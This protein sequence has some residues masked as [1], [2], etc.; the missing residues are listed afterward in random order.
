VSAAS[1]P[2]KI[3]LA[4]LAVEL[5][6]ADA[7]RII[8]WAAETFG[9]GLVLTSSFGAQS[10]VM[11]H[12]VTQVVPEIPVIL[13]DTGYLFPETYQFAHELTERLGLNLKIYTPR[14]TTGYL[15]AVHGRL[16]EQGVEGLTRYHEIVKIEPMQRALKELKVTAWIAGLRRQQ[17]DH[18]ASLRAVEA[19]DGQYKIHPILDWTT[20]DVHEYLKKHDL[21]YHPLY[22]KGYKSIG[23]VHS[24]APITGD[25]H[26]RAGRF[27]GL[28]QECG[29]H[30]PKTTEENDSRLSSGL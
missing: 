30:L 27:A 6:Q 13:I 17:T 20:K 16:W 19:Q 29:L 3:D 1:T 18:R 21:P 8:Q 12:L 28:K 10:A 26:E 23:D 9:E 11:L 25:M 2:L 15:E 7:S 22:A 5:E 4:A 24:T 14:I